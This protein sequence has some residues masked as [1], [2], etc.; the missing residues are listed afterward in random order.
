[1]V[2]SDN[3]WWT[4]KARIQTE[5][6]LLSN[7]FQTQALLLWYSFAS[8]AS[9]VWYLKPEWS[10]ASAEASG[11]AWIVFSVLTL[12]LSG[13]ISGLSFTQRAGL[14]KECYEALN[15]VYRKS[16]SPSADIISLSA[17]YDQILGVCENHTDRDYFMALCTEHLAKHGA[18]NKDTGLKQ[19]L[20]RAPT[21]YHWLYLAKWFAIRTFILAFFYLLPI[22]IFFTLELIK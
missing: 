16:K 9:A 22:S 8:V 2:F 11:V 7:A 21:W 5:K 12:C 13:F 19:G 6:R 15:N 20:D 3:I 17:E 1:M 10:N 4:K 14:I 18:V